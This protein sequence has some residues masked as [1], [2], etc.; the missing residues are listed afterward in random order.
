[1]GKNRAAALCWVLK[2]KYPGASVPFY[3]FFLKKVIRILLPSV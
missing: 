1:M 3:K 2:F